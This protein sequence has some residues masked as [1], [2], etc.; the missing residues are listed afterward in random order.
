M[1]PFCTLALHCQAMV[2]PCLEAG[3]CHSLPLGSQWNRLYG[4]AR[5][6]FSLSPR[7][8][9]FFKIP[10]GRVDPLNTRHAT[11]FSVFL[12]FSFYFPVVCSSYSLISSFACVTLPAWLLATA[13]DTPFPYFPS[14]RCCPVCFIADTLL[15]ESQPGFVVASKERH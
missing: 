8:V 7:G 15:N 3:N 12:Q 9:E 11:S 6:N 14:L 10:P 5:V 13:V 2:F 4:V 1:L